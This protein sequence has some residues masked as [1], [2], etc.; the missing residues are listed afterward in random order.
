MTGA[1]PDGQGG[2]I[3]P[4][5]DITGDI[6]NTTGSKM[7]TTGSGEG[8]GG[9]ESHKD[10]GDRQEKSLDK[11][12]GKATYT[13]SNDDPDNH[14]DMTPEMDRLIRG[15]PNVLTMTAIN[16]TDL[17]KRKLL[18]YLNTARYEVANINKVPASAEQLRLIKVRYI[19]YIQDEEAQDAAT[20][21]HIDNLKAVGNYNPPKN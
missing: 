6:M 17:N 9:G 16:E 20:A 13:S 8:S 19:K 14:P 11:G 7:N 2:N 10:T 12:K 4:T 21:A 1:N 3:K 15:D 18:R 5:I